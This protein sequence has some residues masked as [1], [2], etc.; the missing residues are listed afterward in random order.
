MKKCLCALV[1]VL[2]TGCYT[3]RVASAGA[4]FDN[5][6]DSEV[7]SD[8]QWFAFAGLA[9][10]TDPAGRE[11]QHGLAT[12][13]SQYSFTDALISLGVGAVGGLATVAA[14]KDKDTDTQIACFSAGANL[15]SFLLASRT[16]HYTCEGEGVPQAPSVPVLPTPSNV[17]PPPQN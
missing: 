3:T 12:A 13:S 5:L 10:L 2:A 1:L 8:R 14:C 16:V 11:C 4:S 6:P 15:A 7:H 17:T 9:K